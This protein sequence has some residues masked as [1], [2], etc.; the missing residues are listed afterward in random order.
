MKKKVLTLGFR[1]ETNAFSPSPANMQAYKNCRFNVGEEVLNYNRGLGIEMGAFLDVFEKREDVELIPTVDLNATPSGP[2]TK[3]VY[4][5]VVEQVTAAI[6]AN[7]PLDAVLIGFHGAM[8]SEEHP[9][10]EGDLLEIIREQ[11]GWDIPIM[12]SMDLH[13]NVTPKMARCATVL[14]PYEEYP[15]TDMY[16]TGLET[17]KMMEETLDGKLKPVMA[18]RYIPH[19]LPTIFTAHPPMRPLYDK[20]AELQA[21]PGMRCIRFTHGFF[22]A[23]IEEMGMSVMAVADGDRELAERAAEELAQTIRDQIPNL[24]LDYPTLDEALDRAILPGDGP[25]VLADASDNP[26]AGGLG[27]TTHILRRILERGIT[28]AVVA[29]IC[30]GES[31]KACAAAGVGNT[32]ELN[33]GGWSDPAYSGGPIRCKAYVKMIS[34]GMY[35]FRGKMSHGDLARHGLTALVE[36][37][38]NFVFVTSLPKQPLDLEI[39]RAHGIR[40]EEQK[41]LVVKSTAHYRADYGKVA[42][43]MIALSLPGY[44]V[45]L[46]S[47]FAYKNWKHPV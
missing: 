9:D 12:A 28:G 22:P 46:P 8:V 26:G 2:V 38:G 41:I 15:H 7:S 11:V 36:I 10:G 42:R 23:D 5:Y 32:V 40:P 14:V 6:Q 31:A 19:L 18:Y 47:G 1:H 24:K 21:M 44:A 27:D 3:E 20:A 34:D 43:E 39:F 13:A 35:V 29:T 17:A 37:A 30:D 4:D 33:L 25:V 16:E 45:P